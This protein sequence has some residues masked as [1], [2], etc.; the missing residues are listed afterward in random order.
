ML[1]SVSDI[2]HF[3]ALSGPWARNVEEP[4]LVALSE[5]VKTEDENEFRTAYGAFVPAIR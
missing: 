3:K 4:Y 5:L 2:E 1:L